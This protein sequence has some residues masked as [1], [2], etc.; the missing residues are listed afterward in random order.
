MKVT[1]SKQAMLDSPEFYEGVEYP[2]E[3]DAHLI[4]GLSL[5]HIVWV[6]GEEY[7]RN[8]A[9]AWVEGKEGGVAEHL[10]YGVQIDDLDDID[11]VL[12]KFGLVR[13]PRDQGQQGTME[14]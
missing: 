13:V 9:R 14:A 5:E 12:K 7:I 3:V 11:D 2:C 6:R 1:I 8:G 4:T 10:L